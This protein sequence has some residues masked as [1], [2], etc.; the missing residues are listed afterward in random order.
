MRFLLYQLLFFFLVISRTIAQNYQV[1][2]ENGEG[3]PYANIHE[4]KEQKGVIADENGRFKYPENKLVILS[5]VGYLNDTLYLPSTKNTSTLI[6][7]KDNS[8]MD[9]IAIFSAKKKWR[10]RIN[11]GLYTLKRHIKTDYI[12]NP[13][14]HSFAVKINNPRQKAAKIIKAKYNVRTN[15]KTDVRIRVYSINTDGQPGKDILREPIIIKKANRLTDLIVN[16][17]KYNVIIPKEGAFIGLDVFPTNQEDFKLMVG[18]V[19]DRCA[20]SYKGNNFKDQN[21]EL[22]YPKT[23]GIPPGR[24]R[25]FKFGVVLAY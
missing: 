1:V 12:N 16:L 14:G 7:K 23:W 21:F 15:R 6:L 20:S 22:T 13:D 5:S 3:V 8:Q 9:E 18:I 24:V 25:N 11:A 2:S 17:S 10:G 19:A 4:Y